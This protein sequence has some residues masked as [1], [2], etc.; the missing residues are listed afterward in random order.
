MFCSMI[1]TRSLMRY[2][3]SSVIKKSISGFGRDSALSHKTA[4]DMV[5]QAYSGILHMTGPADGAPMP[6]WT[7]IADV[8][9]GVHAM[10]GIG[11]A[12]FHRERTGAGQHIDISM[13]DALFHS[14][15]LAVQ[16]PS[17][18]NGKWKPTRSGHQSAVNAPMGVFKGPEGWIVIQVMEGQWPGFCRALGRPDLQA[19][20]RFADIRGRQRNRLELIAITEAWLA[21][22]GTDAGALAALDGERVPSAPVLAPH[23]AVG[24]AYYESRGMIRTVHDPIMGALSI[25]G[26]PL[27]MSAQPEQLELIAP[28]LGQHNASVLAELGYSAGEI[29][30]MEVGGTLVSRPL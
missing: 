4:F 26:N 5:A 1:S 19:D 20:E 8:S 16:G 10:A 9:S 30:E 24:N 3:L 11:L 27:R 14:H 7:S 6:V 13:V 2:S 29:A 28:T 12:L 25:P 15:E 23:E 17:V 18:T 21:T 22:M